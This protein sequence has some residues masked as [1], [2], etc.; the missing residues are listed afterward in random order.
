M[1]NFLPPLILI[2]S[3]AGASSIGAQEQPRKHTSYYSG[4]DLYNGLQ[5]WRRMRDRVPTPD[6][7]VSG[8]WQS[9]GY[10]QGVVAVAASVCLP[11][12]V[13]VSN[14]QIVDIVWKH[15]ETYPELRHYPAWAPVTSALEAAFPCRKAKN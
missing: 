12:D 6:S 14:N 8:A 5:D 3:L 7:S 10:V 15:L 1:R 4:N 11:K 9:F 2:M 13:F